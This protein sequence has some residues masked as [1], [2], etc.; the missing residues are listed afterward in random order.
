[1]KR[2]TPIIRFRWWIIVTTLLLVAASIIPLLNI[3]INP[4]LESYLPDSMISRQNQKKINEAFGN[5]EML[6]IVFEA[7]DV[8]EQ[9]TLLRVQQISD[10][11]LR[12]HSLR[13][14][15]YSRLKIF[16]PVTV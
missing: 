4:D 5:E 1:M 10:F 3:H 9:E 8:L 15:H 2:T 6:L 11:L 14:F 12:C 13:F 7:P 16:N